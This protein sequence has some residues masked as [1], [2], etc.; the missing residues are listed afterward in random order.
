MVSRELGTTEPDKGASI[1]DDRL[2]S[3]LS[4]VEGIMNRR[5][6]VQLIFAGKVEKEWIFTD[7]FEAL[8]FWTDKVA[9]VRLGLV[10]YWLTYPVVRHEKEPATHE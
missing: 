1:W 3:V 2:V 7:E 4:H 10:G 9:T 6:V 5:Y 8:K